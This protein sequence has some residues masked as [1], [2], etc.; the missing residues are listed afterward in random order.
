MSE[1][2]ERELGIGI[3]CILIGFC[4]GAVAV[5]FAQDTIQFKVG[6]EEYFGIT[7]NEKWNDLRNEQ[8]IEAFTLFHGYDKY[9]MIRYSNGEQFYN[10]DVVNPLDAYILMETINGDTKKAEYREYK[11][12]LLGIERMNVGV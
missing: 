2:T 3:I 10:N 1:W 4:I 5:M 9:R 6:D 12:W 8:A 7:N 11:E